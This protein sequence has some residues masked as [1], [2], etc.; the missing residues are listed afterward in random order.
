MLEFVH[1]FFIEGVNELA[2]LGIV[3]VQGDGFAFAVYLCV[4][5]DVCCQLQVLPV[6]GQYL[7]QMV[8]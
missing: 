8:F 3:Q 4:V 7:C 2:E 6:L 5:I 1:V